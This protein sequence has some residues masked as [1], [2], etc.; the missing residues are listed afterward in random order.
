MSKHDR[1]QKGKLV[2]MDGESV[3]NSRAWKIALNSYVVICNKVWKSKTCKAKIRVVNFQV[4]QV[5]FLFSEYFQ[6]MFKRENVADEGS[7]NF[8]ENFCF[9]L[10][11]N[12][13]FNLLVWMTVS[14]SNWTFSSLMQW[15]FS[16]NFSIN[17]QFSWKLFQLD[18]FFIF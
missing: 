16:Q 1:L 3:T 13:F 11:Y 17:F 6:D 15:I 7:R 5:F 12:L 10:F 4:S 8:L 2:E 9:F 18:L 14:N